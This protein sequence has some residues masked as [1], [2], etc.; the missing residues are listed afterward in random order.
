MKLRANLVALLV[1]ALGLVACSNDPATSKREITGASLQVGASGALTQDPPPL[2]LRDVERE[3][4]GSPQRAVLQLWFLTQWGS[5]PTVIERY[6]PTVRRRVG[7]S[8]L[9]D[10]LAV[11]RP[12]QLAARPRVAYVL[13]TD[14]GTVVGVDTFVRGSPPIQ[15]SF[16]LNKRGREWLVLYDSVLDRTFSSY[17]QFVLSANPGAKPSKEAV[18]A[19]KAAATQFRGRY[20]ELLKRPG[21]A[22]RGS[23]GSR[24]SDETNSTQS[25]P[26]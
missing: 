24:P 25:N 15:D 18:A 3:R 14:L 9:V 5:L 6:D 17:R 4:E 19:G 1:G 13:R 20:L 21:A 26:D 12:T 10:G 23:E 7:V 22:R 2:S 8:T 11:A 16:L